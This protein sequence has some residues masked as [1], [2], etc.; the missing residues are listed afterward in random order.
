MSLPVDSDSPAVIPAGL[1][2]PPATPR[3][4]PRV[5]ARQ[6][7]T[8]AVVASAESSTVSIPKKIRKV[9]E[10]SW[11]KH[12]K[13]HAAKNKMRFSDALKDSQVRSQYTRRSRSPS[14]AVLAV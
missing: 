9:G 2:T 5:R 4:S 11:I 8:P 13:E 6:P 1:S 7:A 3:R 10:N 14:K 12:V